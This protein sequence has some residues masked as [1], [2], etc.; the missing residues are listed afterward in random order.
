M[1]FN[2]HLQ[3]EL[4]ETQFGNPR[5]FLFS[6]RSEPQGQMARR[7]CWRPSATPAAKTM[8]AEA[9]YS[10]NCMELYRSST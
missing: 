6:E 1:D 3:V 4:E 7:R 9:S 8:K 5:L 2:L 10:A